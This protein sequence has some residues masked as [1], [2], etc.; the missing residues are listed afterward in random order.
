MTRIIFSQ[1]KESDFPLK[2]YYY[3]EIKNEILKLLFDFNKQQK[4]IFRGG[5]AYIFLLNK[6]EY[7]LK[8]IDVFLLEN[9]KEDLIENL[10]NIGADYI[11]LNKN[12]FGKE[13]ITSFWNSNNKYYKVDF[14]LCNKFP[15][16]NELIFNNLKL[17]TVSVSYI[18]RDRL[19]KIAEKAKR[20]HSDL[21]TK[22]H[23]EVVLNLSQYLIE[24]KCKIDFE[25]IDIISKK[26]LHIK[27]ELYNMKN[28]SK[29]E[30]DYF[31]EL[32][33]KIIKNDYFN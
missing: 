7:L 2:K 12:K 31:I 23:Y 28:I 30:C 17:Y 6:I 21:K 19:I 27:H 11:Y 14:L 5:I 20:E 3:Y 18:W 32:Q 25:D 1:Y 13:V 10:K 16:I 24:N 8:D 33:E 15:K 22:N 26:I 29:K 9:Y 4:I